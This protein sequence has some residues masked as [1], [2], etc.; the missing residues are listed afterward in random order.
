MWTIGPEYSQH[1]K[2]AAQFGRAI[3][4]SLYFFSFMCVSMHSVSFSN[5]T[6]VFVQFY[7]DWIVQ[8]AACTAYYMMAWTLTVFFIGT[9]LYLSGLKEDL[10][11]V[12]SA[13]SR[14]AQSDYSTG[15]VGAAVFHNEIIE[16]VRSERDSF[17]HSD[18]GQLSEACANGRQIGR[19]LQ[20][21]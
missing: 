1:R 4:I 9:C 16:Y 11:M 5:E 2:S 14:A 20:R 15:F 7:V 18:D 12:L 13:K 17:E 21:L 8:V 3:R 19:P 6:N 10:R